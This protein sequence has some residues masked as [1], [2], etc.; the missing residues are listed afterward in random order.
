VCDTAKYCAFLA[1]NNIIQ[2][3]LSSVRLH[4]PQTSRQQRPVQCN[5]LNYTE[6]LSEAY[7]TE[8]THRLASARQYIK[9]I[10]P[11]NFQLEIIEDGFSLLFMRSEHLTDAGL[12]LF[13]CRETTN[14]NDEGSKQKESEAVI[15][16]TESVGM[17]GRDFSADRMSSST[18]NI[19]TGNASGVENGRSVI[20]LHGFLATT[21][22]I[23]DILIMIQDCLNEFDSSVRE[24][25]ISN[26]TLLNRARTLRRHVDESLWRLAVVISG[27][28]S[29]NDKP[30]H[31]QQLSETDD[32]S[33]MIILILSF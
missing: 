27:A 15:G 33:G 30:S 16:Q 20:L 25:S 28:S 23:R 31:T 12:S 19:Q 21:S 3:I 26:D 17:I 24:C 14:W 13:D 11:L 8:V 7:K 9:Q 18:F 22:V 2:A 10:L 5:V 1:L 29:S 4:N 32:A 6:T